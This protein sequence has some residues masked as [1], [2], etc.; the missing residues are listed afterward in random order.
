MK[1]VI[2]RVS[3]AQVS[4]EGEVVGSIGRG[5][6]LLVG[7]ERGDG[8]ADALATARKI[9]SLRI[10]PGNK[11]M[12]RSLVDIGGEALVISQ[13]TLAGDLRKGRR[14][15]F[16]RAEQPELAEPLYLAVAAELDTLGV[17]S[18]VGRFGAHME[19]ELV[20]EGPV[21]LLLSTEAGAIVG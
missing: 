19:V 21:T 7:V 2:Q 4:V 3:R 14:P 10:F 12:D 5:V 9:A 8:K 20:N 1:T 16:N 6:M 11:P 15:S 17:P 18:Q 13:F